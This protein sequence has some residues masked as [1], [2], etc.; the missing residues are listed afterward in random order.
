MKNIRLLTIDEPYTTVTRMC[1]CE[2]LPRGTTVRIERHGDKPT[3]LDPEV[4]DE[5]ACEKARNL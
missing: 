2:T 3:V 1:V 4:T 5:Y